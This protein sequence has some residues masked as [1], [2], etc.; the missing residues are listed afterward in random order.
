MALTIGTRTVHVLRDGHSLDYVPLAMTDRV[1]D[2]TGVSGV[3]AARDHVREWQLSTA[4]MSA[5]DAEAL[6]AE[7]DAA[8]PIVVDGAPVGTAVSCYAADVRRTHLSGLWVSLSFSLL[9]A[10]VAS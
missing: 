4:W 1:Y 10:E 3:V 6:E 9:A 2:G 5:D 8:G 7:L